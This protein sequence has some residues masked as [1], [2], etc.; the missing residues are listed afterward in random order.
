MRTANSIKLKKKGCTNVSTTL[1]DLDID[2]VTSPTAKGLLATGHC[3]NDCSLSALETEINSGG[4]KGSLRG[5]NAS[6]SRKVSGLQR[7]RARP[8]LQTAGEIEDAG[9]GQSPGWEGCVLS[10]ASRLRSAQPCPRSLLASGRMPGIWFFITLPSFQ[11]FQM[12][13]FFS[14]QTPQR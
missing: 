9:W 3:S 11:L 6:A 13:D 14:K 1:L 4:S 5:T 12:W 8:A 10:H 7:L 2:G